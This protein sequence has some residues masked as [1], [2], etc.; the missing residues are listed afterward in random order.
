ME[1]FG[2][3]PETPAE[4]SLQELR[5]SD[6]YIGIFGARYG[7]IDPKTGVSVTELEFDEAERLGLHMLLYALDEDAEV[8][9]RDVETRPKAL[10]RM[11]KLMA[12]IRLRHVRTFTT[13]DDLAR[14]VYEDLGKF[15]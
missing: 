3:D 15:R 4:K 6:I 5:E 10:P 11:K 8:K 14:H 13:A 9:K 1:H 7:F 2:A 12:R